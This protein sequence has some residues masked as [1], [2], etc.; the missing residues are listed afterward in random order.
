MPELLKNK[1]IGLSLLILIVLS[2]SCVFPTLWTNN[3]ATEQFPWLGTKPFGFS[4]PYISENKH[5]KVGEKFNAEWGTVKLGVIEYHSEKKSFY[6][7]RIVLRRGKVSQIVKIQGAK[8]MEFVDLSD[9]NVYELSESDELLDKFE[10]KNFKR[11]AVV[12]DLLRNTKKR[13]FIFRVFEQDTVSE[14]ITVRIENKI[15]QS[16]THR[17]KDVDSIM[18]NGKNVVRLIHDGSEKR[19][20]FWM[21]TDSLG[22]CLLA[23]VL[24]G[25]RISLS[26]GVI[27]TLVSVLIGV[28][29][30]SLS[31]YLGGKFDLWFMASVDILYAIPFIFLVILLM[32]MFGNNIFILFFALGC[33]QWLTM[34]RIIRSHVLSLKSFAYIDAARLNGCSTMRV[35]LKHLI[36]NSTG[37]ILV[38]ATLTVPAVILEES[39]LAFIGLSVQYE[40]KSLDSWGALVHQGL[41]E[42]GTNGERAFLLLVPCVAMAITLL[43][44]NLLGDGLRDHYAVEGR[45]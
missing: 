37:P 1:Q 24:Y 27:A 18:M 33:V 42:I 4:H 14:V 6:D 31:G 17:G 2:V 19:R 29:L 38:Y 43:C 15:V 45:K 12:P 25:G 36:P 23:R 21:G 7:L 8:R 28:V 16:I 44:L 41:L 22:R 3:S 32:V 20:V 13:V 10:I 35:L 11:K 26:V 34:S 30:G 40:G 39:F 5:I 9:K